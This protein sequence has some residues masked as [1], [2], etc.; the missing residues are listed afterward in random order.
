MQR[1][2][3]NHRHE[4][5]KSALSALTGGRL[6]AK[7]TALNLV[8]Q[9]V[10]MIVAVVTIP[11]M[12]NSMGVGR[13]GVLTLAWMVVGY[14]S[15]FDMGLGR[16]TTKFVA[17]YLPLEEHDKVRRIIWASLL[18]MLGFGMLGSLIAL[19]LTPVLI[20]SVLNIPADLIDESRTAF[21]LLA[22]SIPVVSMTAGARGVLEAQQRFD[23]VNI[24][25][26]PVYAAAFVSPLFILIFT[27][28][29]VPI[30][31]VLILSR[32]AG[33][34][35]Y[36]FLCFRSTS[37]LSKICFP[38]K[39]L[40]KRLLGY[41]GWLTI[42]HLVWP[43]MNYMDRFVIGAMLTMSAVAYYVTP[44]ELVAKML[45]ITGSFLGVVFPAFSAFSSGQHE[46]MMDLFNRSLKYLLIILVP[47]VFAA[48]T[49]ARP[50]F[51]LWL[52]EEFVLYSAVILQI[53]AV[54]KLINSISQVPSSAIQA[55]GRPDVT[56]K[57]HLAELPL[58]AVM[59]YFFINWMGII[60]AA[61]A[62]TARVVIDSGLYFYLYYRLSP[63]PPERQVKP[64]ADLL[65]WS[66]AIILSAFLISALDSIA[67]KL[68]LA[69]TTIAIGYVYA[70]SHFIDEGEREFLGG[71]WS[72]IT[73][74]RKGEALVNKVEIGL[75][76]D[77][78][79][80]SAKNSI[81]QK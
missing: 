80:V 8:G 24:V 77:R 27:N 33:L 71:I 51:Q 9:I 62:W 17:E 38:D 35:A 4:T 73:M 2:Y 42:S 63:V 7:N 10:P 60:G 68:S 18:L 14:F 29:L 58:Y 15:L 32:L 64:K 11:V 3:N 74:K 6:L 55:M 34:L 28:S 31:A 12:I 23:Y 30:V 40:I 16:A 81:D 57:L 48:V 37:G 19:L 59:L 49:I 76:K 1:E 61:V 70:K 52:G 13:F 26:I 65:V 50:F 67:L 22:L 39:D 54:G 69:V 66:V 5:G 72:K 78:F 41:G 43:F 21:Y 25:K 45:I 79:K 47:V 36:L 46:K 53:L 56:A 75:D 44:Y 20:K